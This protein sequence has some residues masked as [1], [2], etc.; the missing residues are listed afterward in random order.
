MRV[1]ILVLLLWLCAGVASAQ[2]Q[3][4][5]TV[6]SVKEQDGATLWAHNNGPAPISVVLKLTAAENVAAD[7]PL[8]I[9]AVV[10][11]RSKQRLG[12]ISVSDRRLSWRYGTSWS[13]RRGVYTAKHSPDARYRVPWMDGSTFT[14]GQAP[15]GIITTHTT[16]SSREAVDVTMPE[17][18]PIVAARGGT[19]IHV[20]AGFTV[21][22]EDPALR[23]KGNVVRVLHEDGTMGE[24]IHFRHQGVAVREGEAVAPGKLLGYAGSTGFSSG[25][26]LHFAVTRV[27]LQGD[28]L[29]LVSEPFSFYVGNPPRV[30]MPKT[31]VV[32]PADY[33][34]RAVAP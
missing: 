28:A 24:Y 18:T 29:Q 9:L 4:P 15:G 16:P 30:F 27:V 19:V 12:R 3:Y 17:G 31:G 22:G 26:H 8:P 34:A 7:V 13:Y 32:V 20:V 33:G 2:E 21:G 23:D 5:F 14:I 6:E 11:P 1:A 10:E 25:P